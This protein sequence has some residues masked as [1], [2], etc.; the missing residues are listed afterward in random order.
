METRALAILNDKLDEDQYT[1]H[2]FYRNQLLQSQNYLTTDFKVV[3][4]QYIGKIIN[5]CTITSDDISSEEDEAT[6]IWSI[7]HQFIEE[8]PDKSKYSNYKGVDLLRVCKLIQ[9]KQALDKIFEYNDFGRF[10]VLQKEREKKSLFQLGE[11]KVPDI[12]QAKKVWAKI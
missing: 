1:T 5:D 11:P 7:L 8:C 12:D 6:D 3:K 10:Y 9:L 2:K 4:K